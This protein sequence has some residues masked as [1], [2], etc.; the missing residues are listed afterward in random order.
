MGNNCGM[1]EFLDRPLF[2]LGSV[3]ATVGMIVIATVV[4]IVTLAVAWAVKRLTIRHFESYEEG[5]QVAA[6]TLAKIFAVVVFLVGLD[7]VLHIFGFRLTSLFA[8]S[9]V[10]ALGAGFAAK[11]TIENYLSGVILRL[12]KTIRQGDVVVI[13]D[14]LVVIERIGLRSTSGTTGDGVAILVPNSTVAQSIV[15]NLTRDDWLIRVTATPRVALDSDR[16]V[17]REALEKALSECDWKAADRPGE[18]TLEEFTD[19]SIV[20]SVI[21][22]IDEPARLRWSKSQLNETVWRE[23]EAAGV[24]LA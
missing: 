10:L 13:A 20:Y 8:A 12:D 14:R 15:Q 2:S 7:I 9:G 21:I 6:G 18:V 4:L 5:D 11:E 23:L 22:W 24:A 3:D 1:N 19:R 16:S 17:V